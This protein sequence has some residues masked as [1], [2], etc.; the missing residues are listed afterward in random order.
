MTWPDTDTIR[1][2]AVGEAVGEIKLSHPFMLHGLPAIA[3]CTR[4]PFLLAN[5]LTWD[6]RDSQGFHER[7]CVPRRPFRRSSVWEDV[8]R[9]PGLKPAPTSSRFSLAIAILSAQ[10]R[11]MDDRA[12]VNQRRSG[13]PGCFEAVVVTGTGRL[14]AA[15]GATQDAREKFL[16]RSCGGLHGWLRSLQ[17]SSS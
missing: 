2:Q 3:V 9:K 17:P 13:D 10:E 4:S 5:A 7:M 8:S 15:F 12:L 14:K 6:R 11:K 16:R 1:T